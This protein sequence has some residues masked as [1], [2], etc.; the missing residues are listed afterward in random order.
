MHPVH[1]MLRYDTLSKCWRIRQQVL[2]LFLIRQ[3][4]SNQTSHFRFTTR[5]IHGLG[6]HPNTFLT[7]N[8]PSS[9][10]QKVQKPQGVHF[11]CNT[12]TT[13]YIRTHVEYIHNTFY[14]SKAHGITFK[15][16]YIFLFSHKSAPL[17]NGFNQWTTVL[18]RIYISEIRP[19]N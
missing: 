8:P 13:Q 7:I 18:S 16:V 15:I 2:Q 5:M 6:T 19:R 4:L 9:S 14:K 17:F 12:N 10:N 3:L 11:S 1:F